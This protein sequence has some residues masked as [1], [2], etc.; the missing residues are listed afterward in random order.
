MKGAS[1]SPMLR[2]YYWNS[3]MYIDIEEL[4]ILKKKKLTKTKR[5]SDC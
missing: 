5:V 2:K 4:D 1:D 3:D